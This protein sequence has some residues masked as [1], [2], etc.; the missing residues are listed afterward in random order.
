VIDDLTG[1]VGKAHVIGFIGDSCP[2]LLYFSSRTPSAPLSKLRM[3]SLMD[4]A[5][6]ILNSR[7]PSSPMQLYNTVFISPSTLSV[8][9]QHTC[10][11]LKIPT[12]R[13][14]S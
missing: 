5:S 13:I 1:H 14:R 11:H 12:M 8:L 6:K 4:A 9:L 3:L 10:C 7:L 2:E